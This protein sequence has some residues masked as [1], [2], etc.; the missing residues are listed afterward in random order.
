MKYL[1]KYSNEELI[2]LYIEIRTERNKKRKVHPKDISRSDW[3]I[4]ESL[5]ER[6]DDFEAEAQKRKIK[7][8]T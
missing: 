8:P 3:M 1:E 6:M 4:I 7:F 5:R 2:S